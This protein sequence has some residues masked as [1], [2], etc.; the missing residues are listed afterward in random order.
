[1]DIMVRQVKIS[2]SFR[3][4]IEK[5]TASSEESIN[6]TKESISYTLKYAPTCQ[7]DWLDSNWDEV[8]SKD[9]YSEFTNVINYCKANPELDGCNAAFEICKKYSELAGCEE[10]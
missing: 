7:D 3:E 2:E 8:C 5:A 9:R 1:M 10:L 4:L 6:H